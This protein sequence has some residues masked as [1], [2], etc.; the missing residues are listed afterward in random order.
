MTEKTAPQE[1]SSGSQR[2]IT[3]SMLYSLVTCPHRVT[4]DA[5][6]DPA[7][8]DPVNPFVELLWERG[9]SVERERMAA[10]DIPFVD[11]H[12][13]TTREKA[14][15][16]REAMAAGAQLI[17]GGRIE[18]DDLLGEPDLLRKEGTGYVPGDIKSGAG[19]EGGDDE[20]DDRRLKKTY[21]VQLALY[22]DILERLG[23]SAGPRGFIWDV[24]GAEVTY[25]MSVSRGVRNTETWWDFYAAQLATARDIMA[26]THDTLPAYASGTCKLCHWYSSCFQAVKAADDLTLI[27]ELGRAKRDAMCSEIRTVTELA[28]INPGVY[29]KGKKTVFTGIGPDTLAKF[30]E[31]AKLLSSQNPRPYLK[32]PITLP[33]HEVEVFFDIEVD[34]MRDVCYLHGFIERRGRDNSTEKFIGYFTSDTAPEAEEAAFAQAMDYMRRAQPCAIF[35]YSKY[36]RTM[37]RKLQAKY[38]TVCSAD[39]I[40]TLFEPTNTIDLYTDV[41]RPHTEWPTHDLSIKTLAKFLGFHWRDTHP[42]GAA[43]IQW[44]DEWVKTGSLETQQRILDYNEDDCRATRVLLDGIRNLA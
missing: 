31:R 27:S 28:T 38:P 42:S 24:H 10:L 16:T 7:Q 9:S 44:F 35:Y 14:H 17:Y 19:E 39:D 29:T 37:Y 12:T 6:A 25:D 23:L 43:S 21:A 8:R 11:L 22:M 4:M 3:A 26:R 34:P 36:E 33:T 2:A 5:Y 1:F 20:G 41:V 15:K 40:E 32:A 30:H 18:A 13:F